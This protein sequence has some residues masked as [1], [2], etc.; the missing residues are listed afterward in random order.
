MCESLDR[1]R[2]EARAEGKILGEAKGLQKGKNPRQRRRCFNSTKKLVKKRNI[3][4]LYPG[5]HRSFF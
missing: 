3:G 2:E 1:M 5:D 4:F